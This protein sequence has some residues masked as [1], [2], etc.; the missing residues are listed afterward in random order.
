MLKLSFHHT[1]LGSH[2]KRER[3]DRQL[4]QS[5]IAQKAQVTIPTI[6]LLESGQGNLTT[7][8]TVLHTLNLAV[9]GRDLPPGESIGERIVT[10]RK[11]KE[12]SQRALASIIETTQ[13]TLITLEKHSRGRLQTLDRVL[14]ILGAGAYLASPGSPQAFYVHAGNSSTSENWETPKD[15]LEQLYSVFGAFDLDPCSPSSGR[16]APVRAKVHYRKDDDGLSLPWFGTVYMNPPYGRSIHNWTA[17]AKAE[18]EEGNTEMV[19]G[20]I[21]ARTDTAYWHRD[22]ADSASVLF[23]RGRLTFGNAEQVAPF[24]SCLV[25]WGA[26]DE[27]ITAIQAA[28]PMSWLSR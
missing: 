6:R 13:P 4:T 8:W 27:V 7:F 5:D 1:S 14:T 17:K 26:S 25:I 18:V 9:M 28:F 2:L 21:P 3:Q 10:L 23:L 11:R 19:I 22:I 16:T 20:L 15:L 24:P 12:M